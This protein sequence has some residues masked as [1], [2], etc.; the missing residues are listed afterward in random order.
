VSECGALT[1]FCGKMGAGKSTKARALAGE[2]DG[3][4]LSEDAW[5]AALYPDQIA[6]VDDYALYSGRLKA[7]I[8]PL[9]QSILQGG[10]DVVM[11][12][13]ANTVRQRAWLKALGDEI[14]AP[15]RLIYLEVEDAVCLERIAARADA[16][17][18]RRLTD[19]P[20]I[21]HRM[22]AYFDPPSPVEGLCVADPGDA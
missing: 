21:F 17:P 19:T 14:G 8:K 9:V 7:A 18:H 3:V 12:F 10:R 4:L 2:T 5:L 1:F 16:E 13:P 6:S 15:H 22:A 20:E 11:D